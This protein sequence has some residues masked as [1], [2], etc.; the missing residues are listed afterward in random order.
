M[1]QND[2]DKTYRTHYHP[3]L[4]LQL[5]HCS[6]TN[7]CKSMSLTYFTET[8]ESLPLDFQIRTGTEVLVQVFVLL[9][10]FDLGP[11]GS[12]PTFCMIEL[13]RKSF[14]CTSFNVFFSSQSN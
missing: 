6:D 13:K 1:N 9:V 3:S 4:E 12:G 7:L 5:V 10:E 8:E 2:S 14:S 11:A